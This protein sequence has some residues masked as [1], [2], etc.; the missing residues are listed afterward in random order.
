[1]THTRMRLLRYTVLSAS[2]LGLALRALLYATAIDYKGLLAAGH[3][4]TWSILI[5]SGLVLAALLFMTRKVQTPDAYTDCFPA[6]VIRS[7][8]SLA[9]ALV[10]GA[11][12][13][14]HYCTAGDLLELVAAVSGMV[15][16]IG[17]LLVAICRLMGKKPSFLC[18]SALSIFFALQLISQYRRWSADPQLMDYCFYLIALICLM[19]TGYFM[20]GFEADMRS[21]RALLFFSMA[22]TFFCLLALPESG[23]APM[24]IACALW[25]F[26]CSPQMQT[27]TPILK[28]KD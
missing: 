12:S 17:L 14:S 11:R 27:K 6:S 24:L 25:A 20:A 22:A 10:I 7:F 13:F 8:G 26:T 3:W 15:A 16:G 9:A 19:I 23:D 5:L 1:M 21:P 28:T 2:L 4:A 18:H